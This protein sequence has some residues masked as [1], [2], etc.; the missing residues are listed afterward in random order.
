MFIGFDL[1]HI[2]YL[3]FIRVVNYGRLVGGVGA[4]ARLGRDGSRAR[5][6]A[7]VRCARAVLRVVT[8]IG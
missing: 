3:Y 4:D 2:L 8:E 5:A 6:V 1:C 7:R